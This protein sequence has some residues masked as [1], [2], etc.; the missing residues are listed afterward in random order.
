MDKA[1]AQALY[2][3]VRDARQADIRDWIGRF[4][5]AIGAATTRTGKWCRAQPVIAA[6]LKA[7]TEIPAMDDAA[8]VRALQ[9]GW[10]TGFLEGMKEGR[11]EGRVEG[12]DQARRDFLERLRAEPAAFALFGHLLHPPPT[13]APLTSAE[14]PSEAAADEPTAVLFD[15]HAQQEPT[16]H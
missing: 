9:Q 1:G 12:L 16:K 10:A 14:L 2:D 3:H 4:I 7:I 6:A 13:D 15:H 11:A 8:V 5:G